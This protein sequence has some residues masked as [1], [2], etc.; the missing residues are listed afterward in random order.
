[1]SSIGKTVKIGV[2][3]FL[4]KLGYQI[5]RV[6]PQPSAFDPYHDLTPADHSLIKQVAPYTMTSPERI[7]SLCRSVEYVIKAN[8]P[9]DFVEC[10][11]WKGGSAMA[12]ALT[13]QRL[14][15]TD[16]RLYLYD[17][18]DEGWPPGEEID[19]RYDGKSPHELWLEALDRGETPDTLFAKLDNVRDLMAATGYPMDMIVF[20]KGKV[21]ET[22]PGTM[23]DT[24]A[25][26]RL[27]TDW[28]ASTKH[29]LIHLYPRLSHGG[30]LMIDDYAAHK[31][32]AKAVDEYF[33]QHHIN[34]LL[35]RVDSYGYRVGVKLY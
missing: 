16:R 30:V 26:L 23:P 28:Y 27:D 25:L 34:M 29:E 8:I 33:E 20:A 9:G 2:N 14:H 6:G 31:G 19:V 5:Q 13:L 24:I 32:S 22:I 17:T 3:T 11:V 15:Q 35:H 21:E 4:R 1:M 18:F 10:G 7:F 12:M